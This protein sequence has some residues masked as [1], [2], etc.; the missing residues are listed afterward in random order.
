MVY[1]WKPNNRLNNFMDLNRMSRSN[2]QLYFTL[3]ILLLLTVMGC[4]RLPEQKSH[5]TAP[6]R[7][8][9]EWKNLNRTEPIQHII[10]SGSGSLRMISYLGVTDKV[11]AVEQVE[12]RLEVSNPY[13]LVHPE[14]GELPVF[15]EGHG[16]D[17]IEY[18]LNCN[19]RPDVIIRIENPGAGIDPNV[20]QERT[21]I[22]V[23]V[24]PYGD[25]GQDRAVF[26]R[27]LLLLGE[28]FGKQDRARNIINFINEQ[29]TQLE[30]RTQDISEEK[31]PSVYLGGLS[32]RGTHGINST[33][34]VYPPFNWLHVKNPAAVLESGVIRGKQAMVSKEQL[35]SWNPDFF[36]V[37]LGTVYMDNNGGLADLQNQKIYRNIKA[38]QN[39]QVYT[40]YP[41]ISYNI[42]F[43]VMIANAW[44]IGKT[45]Y[46]EQFKDVD[47]NKKIE[48]IFQFML[49][50]PVMP[51]CPDRLRPILYKP[52]PLSEMTSKNE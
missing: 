37:D 15:G 38:I 32:F 35:V 36:F 28:V 52:V 26:D 48:E 40:L 50:D 19:P 6:I 21:G 12:K 11:V 9:E 42:N 34:P 16:R 47:I 43:A 45:V 46:P 30:H 4:N 14:Y 33:A 39:K 31:R 44:F 17:N 41:N 24:I 23:I 2:F 5:Q 49:N 51:R 3:M 13:R 27:S 20:L 25:L 10:C 18:I 29:I 7:T 1:V 8:V 22:P